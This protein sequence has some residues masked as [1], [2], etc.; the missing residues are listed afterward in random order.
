MGKRAMAAYVFLP[1][2]ICRR[3]QR[4]VFF[5][6]FGKSSRYSPGILQAGPRADR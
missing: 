4:I 2:V 3:T 5:P 6:T 1:Q